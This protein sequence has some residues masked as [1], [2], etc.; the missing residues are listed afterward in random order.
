M[1]TTPASASSP[2]NTSAAAITVDEEEDEEWIFSL[3]LP[4]ADQK[5]VQLITKHEPTETV[6]G[7]YSTASTL[8]DYDDDEEEEEPRELKSLLDT[9]TGSGSAAGDAIL[10]QDGKLKAC[11]WKFQTPRGRSLESNILLQL[12]Y[13]PSWQGIPEYTSTL[14]RRQMARALGCC[15]GCR[16]PPHDEPEQLW[17]VYGTKDIVETKRRRVTIRGMGP[18]QALS[19]YLKPLYLVQEQENDDDD[20]ATPPSQYESAWRAHEQRMGKGT[21]NPKDAWT[22]FTEPEDS[23]PPVTEND[24]HIVITFAVPIET[25]TKYD[26]PLLWKVQLPPRYGEGSSSAVML[27]TIT[28]LDGSVDLKESATHAYIQGYQ[29]WSFTGSIWKGEPQPKPAMPNVFSRAFNLGATLPDPPTTIISSAAASSSSSRKG[30]GHSKRDPPFYQSDFFTC[31]STGR[32]ELMDENGGPALLCGWLSQHEQLG[33]IGMDKDLSKIT[34]HAS[35]HAQTANGGVQTDWAYGQL[36]SPH[37]YDEEP[38]VHFL[39]ATAAFNQAKPLQNGPLLTGWCS[40]YH[41]YENI[42]EENLRSNFAKLATMKNKVPTNVAVVDDGYM[43]AWGDWDD[44]KPTK[45]D[46]MGV[47]SR[48]IQ[49]NGMR[50][51]IWLAPFACDKHSKIAKRHPEWIIRNDRGKPANSSNCGKFFYG[52][53]A[54]NP[55]VREHVYESI[56]RAV[57]DWGFQVLKIDFL[58]AACLEGNGKY[59]MTMTRAQAM[60]LA[61]KTIREAAGPDVFLIGCGCPMGSGIGYADG[62]RISA[63]TGPT[64]YPALP[65]PK[66]DQSTLPA[67]RAMIRNSMSR[68]PFGHRWWHNDP[69]CLLLGETTSLTD[70]EVASAATIIAMTCGMMLLSDDLTKVSIARMRIL[71]KIFPMTGV[72]ASV[73]DLHTTRN[74]GMPSIMRLWCTDKYDELE[75]FRQSDLFRQSIKE[76]NHNAEATHFGRGASFNMDE[77]LPHPNERRRSCIP[78]AR[79]LGTWT[80]ISLSNWHD[81]PR[82][83]EI[84]HMAVEPPPT[85]GWGTL[86]SAI[87]AVNEATITPKSAAGEHPGYH[88]FC[89]WS[90]KYSWVSLEDTKH[91]QETPDEPVSALR[92]NLA[93]HET[94][95]FHIRPVTPGV[96]QFV[97]SDLHFSCGHEIVSFATHLNSDTRKVK[98]Q[99]KTNLNRVGHIF[100]FVPTVDTRHV[101]VTVGGKSPGRWSTVGNVPSPRGATI[102]SFQCI[103]RV[104]RIMVVVH[105]DGSDKDG[106]VEIDF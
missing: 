16:G 63:D 10:D 101:Q 54:T 38:M 40:W 17:E 50:P 49:A 71:T 35:H 26:P 93:P 24:K 98:I 59:D 70:E 41:Y 61:L 74:T 80:V 105:G 4:F 43:K 29:S 64:W 2:P 21:E 48:D 84:P 5:T 25:D 69:D 11:C 100:L 28:V 13:R 81:N 66:W 45:F 76:F 30:A 65:L 95:I 46:D 20:D 57:Q 22:R 23:L 89:F 37:H 53:D 12:S 94:E 60:H 42:S 83:M 44:F 56:R 7:K 51:G 32:G 106:L 90:G 62:M 19:V 39:H 102:G 9:T 67:L 91:N 3:F 27:D 78:V 75:N 104:L 103:G 99:L 14:R 86:S 6:S 97:G 55:H 1:A 82:V 47:V 92:R 88:M 33:L 34:M 31:I 96:P 18:C 87:A 52:L 77:P 15:G 58:Y 85:T 8:A 68:A 73:L 79:G 36:V 72:T